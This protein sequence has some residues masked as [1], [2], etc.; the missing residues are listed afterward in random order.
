[1]QTFQYMNSFKKVIVALLLVLSSSF[2]LVAQTSNADLKTANELYERLAFTPAIDYYKKVLAKEDNWDAKCKIA[3]CYRKI[4]DPENA[5]LYYGQLMQNPLVSPE[6]KLFYA[7]MLQQNGKYPAAK[8]WYAEYARLQPND[9][10]GSNGVK[11]CESIETYCKD[12]SL[13][14]I[15]YMLFNSVNSDITPSYY[16]DGIVFA[17]DR[18]IS[19]NNNTYEWTGAP[20]LSFYFTKKTG[21]EFGTP[22]IWFG[23]A[24]NKYHEAG[25]TYTKDLN[26]MYF[27]R[28][29]VN[30]GKIQHSSN[31]TIKLKI[32]HR[33]RNGDSWG[34]A[35]EFPFNSNEYST[36]HP[37]LSA[38][39]QLLYFAS[40]RPGGYGL[41]DIY[42]C[43]KEG[44][45]W[46][47][48][49]NL[50][51]NINTE[52]NEM[53]P[54]ISKD[55][56]LYFASNGQSGLG[57]LD[58][59]VST[60]QN[61]IWTV[62]KNVGAPINSSRDDFGLVTENGKEGYFASNRRGSD[63]IYSFEKTCL[64]L[65]G[66]VY[67]IKTN[68]PIDLSTVKII[69]LGTQKEV[70]TTDKEGKFGLC[71]STEHDY[72][73]IANKDGYLENKVR[74]STVNFKEDQVSLR[75]PL[76]KEALFDLKGK[77]YNESTK[78]PMAGVKVK[79]LNLCD[80][81]V[82]EIITTADGKYSFK[83]QPECKYKVTAEK[84]GCGANS[85]ERSTVGL[86]TTQTLYLDFGMLCT[87]D[88]V[89][90]DN[91]YYD[92]DKANIR[93]DAAR[94]LDKTIEVL[95]KYPTMKIEL[96]SHTDCRAPDDYNLNLSQRRA[97][98][99]VNYLILKG[100]AKNRM[101]ATGYGETLPVNRCVDGVQ[102]S[103]AEHQT[104]RRTE[105][106][107]L[108]F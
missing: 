74:F 6:Q 73:F 106:K 35:T 42:V 38:D 72:E 98:S 26:E 36:G 90:I 108:S 57:G 7:Q 71:L 92:L 75:I 34:K 80:N 97:Q 103:D 33:T 13:V 23:K 87:G 101:K 10:R 67:D 68:E 4:N 77:V 63:D 52:G 107:I 30:N 60:M 16:Q 47:L 58:I 96:R 82:E 43:K 86:K 1:M 55:N 27:T 29:N 51:P 11:A 3:D 31:K 104:N 32:Y 56:K 88:I 17:S 83:L 12:S 22:S 61:G 81:K 5:A 21:D 85:Q 69:D 89:K 45:G 95:S 84:E 54:F 46:S 8:L 49:Q 79:L 65:N 2:S 100:V 102:C 105:F 25:A 14:H 20:F 62:P 50:G 93:P 78:L 44:E 18:K 70:K 66:V 41:V 19:A 91:I 37:T 40:D 76:S 24:N 53:F 9:K 48:P 28:A 64:Q 39:G 59:Y 15:E 99:A 94:E